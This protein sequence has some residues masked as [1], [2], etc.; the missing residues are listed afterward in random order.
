MAQAI[1]LTQKLGDEIL[2]PSRPDPSDVK[3]LA[4]QST[5]KTK[6]N[7]IDLKDFEREQDP[8]E[9]VSLKVINDIEELDKVFFATNQLSQ[10]TLQTTN[11]GHAF[12][13][14]APGHSNASVMN[15]AV[16]SN[17][18]T[19]SNPQMTIEMQNVAQWWGG[20]GHIPSYFPQAQLRP[21]AGEILYPQHSLHQHHYQMSNNT[22]NKNSTAE[23]NRHLTESSQNF[24]THQ[25]DI[26][27]AQNFYYNKYHVSAV[28]ASSAV[29]A[30]SEQ[31]LQSNLRHAKS[32]PD[33]VASDVEV[34][35]SE[36]QKHLPS[37]AGTSSYLVQNLN[38]YRRYTPPLYHQVVM[39]CYNVLLFC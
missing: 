11:P 34:E 35:N 29:A 7:A 18:Q 3:F 19:T 13:Q 30:P 9:N 27:I 38:L 8:F 28:N 6:V 36:T 21:V 10:S 2:I 23:F 39:M 32:T 22:S 16:T 20:P 25:N 33:M 37:G 17:I 15:S 24:S 14:G 12:Y 4:E 1:G 31:P 26:S 5:G